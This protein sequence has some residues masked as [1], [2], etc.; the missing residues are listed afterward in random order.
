MTSQERPNYIAHYPSILYWSYGQQNQTSEGGRIFRKTT[1]QR[2]EAEKNLI[3]SNR[4]QAC[5]REEKT[6]TGGQWLQK[7]A[8]KV[9][10]GLRLIPRQKGLIP[11]AP[12]AEMIN[13][14]A[15]R[16]IDS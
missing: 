3:V 1:G 12:P 6:A 15:Q 11:Q 4:V 2:P 10:K 13:P 9:V 16:A 5:R 14:P 7:K 8:E